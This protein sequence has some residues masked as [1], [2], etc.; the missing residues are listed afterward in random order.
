MTAPA[1]S[2]PNAC[3]YCGV[4]QRVHYQRWALDVGSRQWVEPPDWQ[5]KQRMLARRKA[6]IARTR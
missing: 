6:R 3:T 5:R 4:E 1:E 2:A